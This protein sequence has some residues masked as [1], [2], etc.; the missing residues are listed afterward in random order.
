MY[1]SNLNQNKTQNRIY[2]MI[3]YLSAISFLFNESN[4]GFFQRKKIFQ[5]KLRKFIN[6]SVIVILFAFMLYENTVFLLQCKNCSL[7]VTFI[8]YITFSVYMLYRILLLKCLNKL[9]VFKRMI[10]RISCNYNENIC[11][12]IWVRIW[13]CLIVLL[14]VLVFEDSIKVTFNTDILKTHFFTCEVKNNVWKFIICVIFSYANM[15]LIYMPTNIFAVYYVTICYE[16]KELIFRF[17]SLIKH[18][19]KFT[20]NKLISIYNEIRYVIKYI[21]NNFGYLLFISFV[22]NGILI[23]IGLSSFLLEKGGISNLM[24]ACTFVT[25]VCN[26]LSTTVSASNIHVVSLTT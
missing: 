18:H 11:I 26:Y 23:H 9:N 12:P 24:F 20:Y 13:I 19:Q 25:S 3:F 5:L 1:P 2:K 22:F 14:N 16:I 7:A 6:I 15:I 10:S 17:R 8:T 4:F 21:D